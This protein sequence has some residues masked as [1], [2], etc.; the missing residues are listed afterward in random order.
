MNPENN[1]T[2]EIHYY[3]LDGTLSTMNSTFDFITMYLK[4]RKKFFRLYITKTIMVNLMLTKNYH[5]Y[6][7]RYLMISMLF[8]GLKRTDL[9]AFFEEHYKDIFLQSLT[10][11]GKKIIFINNENNILITGC[12]EI[13]ALLIG[14][15]FGF[16]QIISTTFN[17]NGDRIKGIK[18]DTY[19]NLKINFVNESTSRKVYYT[20]D[21]KSEQD[22]IKFMDE[23]IEV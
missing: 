3:D 11:L 7:S 8:R 20:D 23:I 5:P 22:L 2:R 15:I 12:T 14:E 1:S 4:K 6:K 13:P 16:K 18:Q 21:L 10:P 9:E 17:Y 19:G